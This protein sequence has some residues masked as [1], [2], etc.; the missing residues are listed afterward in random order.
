[1]TVTKNPARVGEKQLINVVR[2][3]TPVNRPSTGWMRVILPQ[4]FTLDATQ[5]QPQS[6][7]TVLGQEI[8]F[9]SD[10]RTP[11]RAA[12]AVRDSRHTQPH[13]PRAGA[14]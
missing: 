8:R 9:T 2:R 12:A 3:K 7:A 11:A 4:E 1:M 13:R 14:G 5:I 6:E 10:H